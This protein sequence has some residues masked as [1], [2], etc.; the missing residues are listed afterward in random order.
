MKFDQVRIP[1]QGKAAFGKEK[2][3]TM[4]D[5]VKTG[6]TKLLAQYGI[7]VATHPIGIGKAYLVLGAK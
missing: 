1:L 6:L 2:S 3:L 7:S 4:E 5:F